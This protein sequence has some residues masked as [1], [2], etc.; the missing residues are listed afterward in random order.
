MHMPENQAIRCN[1]IH[2]ILIHFSYLYPTPDWHASCRLIA[3]F[4]RAQDEKVKECA[5]M[6]VKD[7]TASNE[8]LKKIAESLKI[9]LDDTA[10]PKVEKICED[11]NL[12]KGR[13]FDKA[14]LQEMASGHEKGISLFEAGQKV[15]KEKQVTAFIDKTLP[16][17]RNHAQKIAE[18]GGWETR[19]GPRPKPVVD[20]APEAE[21]KA[22]AD[23]P[24]SPSQPGT[25][26][27]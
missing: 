18:I 5:Q 9:R 12:K 16:V 17:L 6:L 27:P 14:F 13:D 4:K 23:R 19:P 1:G 2:K 22:A 8:E 25:N 11:L 15:S 7:H 21:T 26:R 24:G 20:P 3:T 10:D